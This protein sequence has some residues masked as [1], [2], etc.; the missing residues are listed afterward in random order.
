MTT[1]W[2]SG[3]VELP[4][5]Q[6]ARA[7]LGE[8]FEL[9]EWKPEAPVASAPIALIDVLEARSPAAESLLKQFATD[10]PEVPR[11]QFLGPWCDGIGRTPGYLPGVVPLPWHAWETDLPALLNVTESPSQELGI[12]VGIVATS[13]VTAEALLDAVAACGAKSIWLRDKKDLP[14]VDQVL[15]DLEGSRDDLARAREWITAA[16]GKPI[17]A[18]AS[19]ARSYDID[20]WKKHGISAVLFKPFVLARLKSTLERLNKGSTAK[21]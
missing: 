16:R 4:E 9:I 17:L 21:T 19:F 3:C 5:F 18:A 13:P 7:W 20:V 15:V 14:S 1:I 11:I 12:T 2:L 6:P 10:F 8:R